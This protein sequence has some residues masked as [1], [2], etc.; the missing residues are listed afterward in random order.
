MAHSNHNK[1][2][3]YPDWFGSQKE[4]VS[5]Q[6]S[7]DTT[8]IYRDGGSSESTSTPGITGVVVT[9]T[10]NAVT[11]GT[12]DGTTIVLNKDLTF[13]TESTNINL[14][15]LRQTTDGKQYLYANYDVA[16][17]G[18]VTMYTDNGTIDL[19]GLYDG[20]PIDQ[21]TL[22]WNETATGKVLSINPNI[23]LGGASSWDEL[24]GKP[25]WITTSKPMYDY[26][27]IQN[28]PDLSKYVTIDDYQEVKGIKNFLN[29]LQI[30]GLPIHKLE[31]YE[32]VIYIDANLVVRGGVTMYGVNDIVIDSIIDALPPA[33]TS[34]LGVA[35]FHPDD[36]FID[37]NGFVKMI[38]Q[39]SGGIDISDLPIASTS[40][41]GIAQF[42][43]QHFNVSNGIVDLKTKIQVVS[44]TPSSFDNNTLYV[45]I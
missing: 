8:V 26:S 11:S 1:Y 42:N 32:D 41:K 23:D 28:T 13:L 17:L 18:G 5:T 40:I 22:V 35:K 19:P 34:S 24:E 7:T 27:E 9:G 2:V 25:S 3:S 33:S 6:T 44:T 31:G 38:Q 43:A 39:D 30:A 29:G 4:Q 16:T 20:L 21:Q 12:L 10:G 14:W 45:I 15:E 36:F 37:E